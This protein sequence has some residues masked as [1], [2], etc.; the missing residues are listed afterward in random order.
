MDTE[1]HNN[2]EVDDEEQI[3]T[4]IDEEPQTIEEEISDNNK[5]MS[6]IWDAR[7]WKQGSIIATLR[8]PFTGP[9]IS[10]NA[11]IS[12]SKRKPI[13]VRTVEKY[14]VALVDH[15][16]LVVVNDRT[17][18]E[19]LTE[20]ARSYCGLQNN[21]SNLIWASYM[22]PIWK[23][24]AIELAID[25][26]ERLA[27]AELLTTVCLKACERLQRPE[28]AILLSTPS[29]LHHHLCAMGLMLRL[30]TDKGRLLYIQLRVSRGQY[31][32]SY[33]VAGELSHVLVTATAPQVKATV[34]YKLNGDTTHLP[35]ALSA[36]I[37]EINNFDIYF[38]YA[39]TVPAGKILRLPQEALVREFEGS[40]H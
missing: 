20:G 2:V 11:T 36:H 3:A 37:S 5:L 19:A 30:N 16:P 10:T 26:E 15:I 17:V 31:N 38:R 14:S 21:E 1:S 34:S 39:N 7:Y 8:A 22:W 35:I 18:L 29:L 28:F 9:P 23:S 12:F 33:L 40:N 13:I 4:S 25:S 24:D 6:H 27:F 32:V